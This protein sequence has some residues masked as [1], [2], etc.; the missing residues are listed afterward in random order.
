MSLYQ[1]IRLLKENDEQIKSVILVYND[2]VKDIEKASGI[3]LLHI[4]R[5]H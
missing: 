3:E 2:K 1:V 5:I 4:F